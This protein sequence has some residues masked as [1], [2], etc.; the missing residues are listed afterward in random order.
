MAGA[1]REGP[2]KEKERRYALV[3]WSI[4]GRE[5]FEYWEKSI[6]I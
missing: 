2:D 1:D 5:A 3:V 6:K 4:A